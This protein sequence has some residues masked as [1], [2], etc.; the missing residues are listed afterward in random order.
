MKKKAPI[1]KFRK[2]DVW[3]VRLPGATALSK[4]EV[5]DRTRK[6]V[7]L[8]PLDTMASSLYAIRDVEF[9]EKVS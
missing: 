8:C 4:L 1:P 6:V 3:Y 2:G 5:Y 7:E 9:V